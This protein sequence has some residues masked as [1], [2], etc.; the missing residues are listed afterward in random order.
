MQRDFTEW[1]HL[2]QKI[3]ARNIPPRFSERELWWANIGENIG[4]KE[5]G[6]GSQFSRPVL[7]LR[8]FSTHLFWGIPLTTQLKD[9]PYY[10]K[11]IINGREQCLMTSQLTRWDAKRLTTRMGKLTTKEFKTVQSALVTLLHKDF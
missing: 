11:I 5:N 4:H 7:I 8:K 3:Q 2:K 6:K 1:T 9:T 10:H